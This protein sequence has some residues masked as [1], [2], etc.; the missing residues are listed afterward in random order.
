MELKEKEYEQI[1][2]KKLQLQL[3]YMNL[4]QYREKVVA[5][6]CSKSEVKYL[7]QVQLVVK[8]KACYIC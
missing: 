7:G 5:K 2:K 3:V 1:R 8:T 6:L 4:I